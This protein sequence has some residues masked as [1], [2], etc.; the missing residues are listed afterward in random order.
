MFADAQ[1]TADNAGPIIDGSEFS[2]NDNQM[3][4]I[5]LYDPLAT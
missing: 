1:G 5:D 3:E 2:F 4:L